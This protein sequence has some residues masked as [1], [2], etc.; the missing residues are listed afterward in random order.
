MCEDSKLVFCPG[1]YLNMWN[2]EV[3]WNVLHIVKKGFNQ[4]LFINW[5]DEYTP[6]IVFKDER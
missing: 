2:T 4:N 3:T 5:Y 6:N 1:P